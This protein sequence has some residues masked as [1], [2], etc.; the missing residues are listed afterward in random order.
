[1]ASRFLKNNSH[2]YR[3]EID[4]YQAQEILKQQLNKIDAYTGKILE[5][6]SPYE[7]IQLSGALF[8]AIEFLKDNLPKIPH[9]K[10]IVNKRL[11]YSRK[12]QEQSKG[13]IRPNLAGR[14][15]HDEETMLLAR[16]FDSGIPLAEISKLH[17]RT[18]NAIAARLVRIGKVSSR[19]EA[20]KDIMR[21]GTP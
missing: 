10:R 20:R 7:N 12:A 15:W 16:R 21:N 2:E 13:K 11:R 4:I 3:R 5:A 18:E 9:I 17:Q 14:A 1:M 6:N 8:E 19:D